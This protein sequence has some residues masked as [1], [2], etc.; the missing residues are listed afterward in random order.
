MTDRPRLKLLQE[1]GPASAM[2]FHIVEKFVSEAESES[3][4]GMAIVLISRI[5]C[6]ARR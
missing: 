6:V 3:V 5:F 1:R 2:D 4:P